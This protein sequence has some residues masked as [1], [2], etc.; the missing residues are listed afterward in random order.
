MDVTNQTM[1]E[2]STDRS[3]H[4]TLTWSEFQHYYYYYYYYYYCYC[5]CYYCS[6]TMILLQY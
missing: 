2:R 3:P 4:H 5:C 6:T 1:T